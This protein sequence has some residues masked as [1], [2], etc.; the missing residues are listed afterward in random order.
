[1]PTL[2]SVRSALTGNLKRPNLGPAVKPSEGIKRI[3]DRLFGRLSDWINA[4]KRDAVIRDRERL[5]ARQE[6]RD[7]LKQNA[8]IFTR[9][10][11]SF[12]GLFSKAATRLGDVTAKLLGADKPLWRDPVKTLRQRPAPEMVSET[13]KGN[14][15]IGVN[16]TNVFSVS[17]DP[18]ED[19][20][21]FGEMH[22]Q[23]RRESRLYSYDDA[24][25][26]LYR[27]LLST[28][29]PGRFVWAYVRAMYD[30]SPG[31]YRRVA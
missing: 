2:D 13:P 6:R 11:E 30:G 10:K 21:K 17:F 23:F 1:M 28:E 31:K 8:G 7:S 25:E 14:Q 15:F 27:G 12:G 18:Y 3:R 5:N 26:W 19:D 20:P 24:P 22:I 29:S 16:S 4:R 9:F